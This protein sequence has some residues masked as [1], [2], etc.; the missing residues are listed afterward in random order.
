MM[1]KWL[2]PWIL[3]IEV[4]FQFH[5]EHFT[6]MT[7]MIKNNHGDMVRNNNNNNNIYRHESWI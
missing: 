5:F 1:M 2:W 3:S 6:I 7:Y 4:R